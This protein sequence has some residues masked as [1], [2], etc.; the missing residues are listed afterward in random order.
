MDIHCISLINVKNEIEINSHEYFF[1]GLLNFECLIDKTCI[2]V[3][4]SI[5]LCLIIHLICMFAI[6]I[7]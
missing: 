6:K 7:A 4:I 3:C 1:V 5:A 2:C